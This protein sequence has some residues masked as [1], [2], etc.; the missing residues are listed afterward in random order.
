MTNDD[1]AAK[2]LE[3]ENRASRLLDELQHLRTEANHYTQAS[4]SLESAD[5]S[6]QVLASSLESA[7]DQFQSL[8]SGLQDIGMPAL[9]DRIGAL[10]SQ[11][12]AGKKDTTEAHS[13]SIWH[14]E[15][16]LD[17]QS[18]GMLGKLFGKPARPEG[19]H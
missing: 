7:V 6:I 17:Y 3:L 13:K 1:S 5:R 2:F 18:R 4:I 12:E 8:I 11:L 10:E 19:E 9:L 15:A 16:L 14:L